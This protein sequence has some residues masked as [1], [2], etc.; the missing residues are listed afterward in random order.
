MFRYE[1]E[2]GDPLASELI[3]LAVAHTRFTW[4]Q[5]PEL[6]MITFIDTSKV[7]PI[8]RRG[9]DLWGYSYLKAGFRMLDEKTKGGLLV[10]QLLLEDMPEPMAPWKR[11]GD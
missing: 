3:R 6:G 11:R 9:K 1:R 7:S 2:E 8:K 4:P 5:V 10:F